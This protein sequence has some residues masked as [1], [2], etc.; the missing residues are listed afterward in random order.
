[1]SI[2][3]QL[4]EPPQPVNHFIVNRDS[5]GRWTVRDARNLIGGTLVSR[6]A[7]LHF[8][9]QESNYLPGAVICTDDSSGV[10]FETLFAHK[11]APVGGSV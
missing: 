2:V 4:K 8:A 9:R 5:V 1:M 6:S 11:G 7:A 10:G 3:V